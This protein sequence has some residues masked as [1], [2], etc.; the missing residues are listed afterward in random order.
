MLDRCN[1]S[2]N[3]CYRLYGEKGIRVCDEWALNPKQFVKWSMENGY[4]L[5]MTIERIDT[6][7]GYYPENCRYIPMSEQPRNTDRNVFVEYNGGVYIISDV[8]RM[9][10]VSCEAIRKRLRHKWY[11]QVPNPNKVEP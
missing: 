3:K 9:E 4:T 2:E 11:K 6:S 1:N 8:A 7:K 5:G 10:G